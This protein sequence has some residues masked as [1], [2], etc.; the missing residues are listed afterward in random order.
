MTTEPPD[1]DIKM[2]WRNQTMEP[3]AIS[4]EALRGK[5]SQFERKVR[6]R[7]LTEYLASA[8]VILIFGWYIWAFPGW[9]IKLGSALVI[10]AAIY[11]VWRLHRYGP[12]HIAP[13][14]ASA[15]DLL[16]F[17]RGELIR[18]R[19]LV[20]TVWRWYLA[21]FVPGM[22]LISLGRWFQFHEPHRLVALD[23]LVIILVSVIATLVFAIVWLVNALAAAKLQ[24]QI[25]EL[26]ALRGG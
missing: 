15:Q 10:V 14:E 11:I 12:A 19:D 1:K 17:H 23:H 13:V 7:N 21:P 22:V 26:D 2:I 5:A 9:M 8:V 18:Q 20:K 25:D 6:R 16:E 4:L 3:A 24:R